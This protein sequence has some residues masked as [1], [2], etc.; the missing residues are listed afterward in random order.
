MLLFTF[1]DSIG[2]GICFIII[3]QIG[4][5]T[6]T[7]VALLIVITIA[8]SCLYGGSYINHIDLAPNFA[9]SIAGILHTIM[10]S[11]GIFTPL[12]VGALTKKNVSILNVLPM[13]YDSSH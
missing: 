6:Y 3:T 8:N 13:N 11:T 1:P 5:H 10:N 4:C 9:G 2:G 7:I 12:V